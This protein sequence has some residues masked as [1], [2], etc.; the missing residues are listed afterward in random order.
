MTAMFVQPKISKQQAGDIFAARKS[1]RDFPS[2][3]MGRGEPSIPNRMELIYIPYYLFDVLVKRG[4]EAGKGG[5]PGSQKVRLSVD[6]L[7]GHAVL[8][9]EESLDVEDRQNLQAHE[10]SISLSEAEKIVL[11][12]Y[13]GILLEH[14][15]RTRSLSQVEKILGSREIYYPF[16]IGYFK[17][18]KG[19]DFKALDAVSGEV[20]GI[21]MRKI[22]LHAFRHMGKR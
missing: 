4:R 2:K 19:Y 6:G 21:R 18:G 9:A 14:G 3:W 5:S 7:L 16:W 17:K 20:Q 12:E 8:F 11:E 1:I 13:R 22:F 15:L 10:F